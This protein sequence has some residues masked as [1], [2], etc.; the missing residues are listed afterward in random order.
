VTVSI[1]WSE[2]DDGSAI[3]DPLDHGQKAAGQ[4]TVEKT[5]WVRHDGD[6][7]IT[8][9]K[10]WVGEYSASY[11]GGASAASDL[12]ELIAWAD[13]TDT[14]DFGGLMI[15]MDA[16]GSFASSWPAVG[17]K[18][19]VNTGL[20]RTGVGDS[21]ANGIVLATEMSSAMSTD[22]TIP[23]NASPNPSFKARIQV[24]TNEGTVGIRQFDMK[25]R[26]TY[27]S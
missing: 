26:F 23:I 20:F 21:A 24:P 4:T 5:I 13:D 18:D 17:S 6:Y 2:T 7:S 12:A 19:P 11:S 16:A 3:S 15:H 22:G 25:L 9:C 8:N 27:S 1:I 10:F 14:D